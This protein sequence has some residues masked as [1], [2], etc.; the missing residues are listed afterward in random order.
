M[1]NFRDLIEEIEGIVRGDAKASGA[2]AK[3][4]ENWEGVNLTEDSAGWGPGTSVKWVALLIEGL[5]KEI[6]EE[7]AIQEVQKWINE[8]W[9]YAISPEEK[10]VTPDVGTIDEPSYALVP[11]GW[12]G[13]AS[14]LTPS[15]DEM[16]TVILKTL[17]NK[18]PKPILEFPVEVA[19]EIWQD[20]LGKALNKGIGVKWELDKKTGIQYPMP[21]YSVIYGMWKDMVEKIVGVRPSREKD[22]KMMHALDNAAEEAAKDL[23]KGFEVVGKERGTQASTILRGRKGHPELKA[24][25]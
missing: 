2:A 16:M 3:L 11:R 19:K 7:K 13:R 15:A 17:M 25:K 21:D 14:G 8:A 20:A 1:G 4:E 24:T 23:A 6:G 5:S 18:P 22:V 9:T 12:R 10:N